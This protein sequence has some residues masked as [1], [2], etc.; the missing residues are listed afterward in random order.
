MTTVFV[1]LRRVVY[2]LVLLLCCVCVA[3]AASPSDVVQDSSAMRSTEI[4]NVDQELGNTVDKAYEYIVL[5]SGCLSLMEEEMK[6]CK[7]NSKRAE[8]ASTNITKLLEEFKALGNEKEMWIQ[9]KKDGLQENIYAIGNLTI[10]LVGVKFLEHACGRALD[11]LNDNVKGFAEARKSK[12]T[13]QT[14]IELEKKLNTTRDG[15]K[16]LWYDGKLRN[17]ANKAVKN[18]MDDL[19][20]VSGL[21]VPQAINDT[22]LKEGEE[23]GVIGKE[24]IDI[25]GGKLEKVKANAPE[26]IKRLKREELV[27]EEEGNKTEMQPS[28]EVGVTSQKAH[29]EAKEKRREKKEALEEEEK[30]KEADEEKIEESGRGNSGEEVNK[31]VQ[32]ENVKEMAKEEAEKA[33]KAIQERDNSSSPALMHG[34][35]LVLLLCVLGCTLVC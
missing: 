28:G 21:H 9:G 15:I 11:G 14:L 5:V 25:L 18:L 29:E 17:E 13:N 19:G 20:D 31:E 27:E 34:P 4:R 30:R 22:E 24:R 7:E 8:V 1:Q 33:I 10:S 6:L 32:G 12:K 16:S 2:L 23:F 26:E 3:Y 35:L